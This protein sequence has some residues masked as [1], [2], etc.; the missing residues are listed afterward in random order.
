[1]T[2]RAG[3]GG[4]TVPEPERVAPGYRLYLVARTASTLALT[5]LN[6][7]VAWSLYESSGNAFYLG[8]AGLVVFAPSLL[9][10][11]VSGLVIDRCDRRRVL[12]ASY[13]L[14][15]GCAAA[16]TWL[17]RADSLRPGPI[18]AV[19]A[20][21]GVARAFYIPTVKALLVNLVPRPFLP[22]A[23]AINSSLAKIAV[24][25]GPIL[26]GLLY[27]V[28]PVLPFAVATVVFLASA[29]T[30][31]ALR[32][33]TQRTVVAAAGLGQIVG[34][35][36]A[37]RRDAT[38]LGTISLDF[39]AMFIGGATAL[40]PVFAK[41]VL[42]ADPVGLGL[43]RA[44]PAAGAFTMAAWF[45]WH[46]IRR[47]AGSLMLACVAGYGVTM[48]VFGLSTE[49]WLSCAALYLG[50]LLDMVSVNVRESLVQLRTPDAVRGRVTAVNSVVVGA[51]NELSD[52]RAGSFAAL[53]GAGPSVV[54]GG[55]AAVGIAV[56][57]SRAFP[58][59]RRIDRLG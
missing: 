43:L 58:H 34:G 22:Q 18:L 48:V 4:D 41:D 55:V 5:T 50:G 24:V 39:C 32:G 1:M 31:L 52:F 6:L 21:V 9:L 46:P 45:A 17:A 27:S 28:S 51:S 19:L 8:L 13:L 10:L 49:F 2:S 29:L 11:L 57:W 16:L 25:T 14:L 26:G 37:I 33:S 38:L 56:L 30:V 54:F 35:L 59:L 20:C 47:N 40:L 53:F 15:A 7:V 3:S 23:I 36:K 44:S 12:A 42:G